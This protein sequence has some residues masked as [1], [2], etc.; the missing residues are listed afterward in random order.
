M[1][2]V[3]SDTTGVA[4]EMVAPLP[5]ALVALDAAPV[6]V[7]GLGMVETD[8]DNLETSGVVF[9]MVAVGLVS[10]SSGVAPET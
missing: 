7:E 6:D 4:L 10:D 9:E 5:E 2:V 1:V 8:L 3:D